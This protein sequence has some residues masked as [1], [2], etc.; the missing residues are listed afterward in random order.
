MQDNK[1]KQRT[2][3]WLKNKIKYK[4]FIMKSEDTLND[5]S[6][7]MQ[8][9]SKKEFFNILSL[10]DDWSGFKIRHEN[11]MMVITLLD[12]A[13]SEVI[14]IESFKS[15]KKKRKQYEKQR[16][17]ISKISPSMQRV[18]KLRIYDEQLN[19]I[20]DAKMNSNMFVTNVIPKATKLSKIKEGGFIMENKNGKFYVGYETMDLDTKIPELQA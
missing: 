6:E 13:R 9:I 16:D 19:H 11:D 8:K 7:N 15:F 20:T 14:Y 10:K 17:L 1:N 4:N 5:Y 2:K 3:R 12:G 18:L